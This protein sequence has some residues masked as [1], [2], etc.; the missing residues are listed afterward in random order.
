MAKRIGAVNTIVVQDDGTLRG[1]NNDGVGFV[2]S[3]YDAKPGWKPGCGRM[4]AFISCNTR[5]NSE[6]LES[7][8]I[9]SHHV[10]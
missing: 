4:P 3:V 5:A 10:A 6:A 7:V 2:Q 1:F 8:G 9:A